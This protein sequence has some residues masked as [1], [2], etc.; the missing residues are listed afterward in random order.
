MPAS[1]NVVFDM[2]N[3]LMTFDGP[4]F[5]RCFT[6]TDADA[7][8]LQAALFGR[9]EWALLDAGAIDHDTMRRVAES[10][11]PARL[12]GNLHECLEHWPERS[13]PIMPVCNLVPELKRQGTGVYLLSNASTRI[14]LQL[15][16]C[17]VYPLMDGRVVSGFERIMKPD[18]AI[19]QLLC[20]RYRLDSA[21]C[22]FID[23]N[24]DNCRG[25]EVAGMRAHRFDGD[26]NALREALR[27]F[28]ALGSDLPG[29]TVS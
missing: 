20:T 9:A 16:G 22:I 6:E 21:T 4:Y 19:Y 10:H 8:L 17:P 7:A 1:R 12:H 23:D 27:S 11:L 13:Q 15:A 28:G 2:G 14:D 26:V 24:A 3:V 29:Q 5:S 25:A 18:P